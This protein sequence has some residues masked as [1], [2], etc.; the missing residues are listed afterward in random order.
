MKKEQRAVPKKNESS[1][2]RRLSLALFYASFTC[3]VLV[4]SMGFALLA[5]KLFIHYDVLMHIPP[6]LIPDVN[7]AILFT[8]LVSLTVG[9]LLSLP[10]VQVQISPLNRVITAMNRLASGDYRERLRFRRPTSLMPSYKEMEISFN[11][12]AEE[13]ENTEL[14]RS[15]FINNFSH[16]FKTP[17][18]SIAGFARLLQRGELTEEQR[19]EYL[20]AIY[21]ESLR[22]SNMATNVL[23]LSHL[24]KQTILSH[25]SRYNVSEQIRSC[26]L[27]LEHAWS[28][29]NIDWEIEMEEYEIEGDEELIKQVWINILSNA[30]KFSPADSC[31]IL[32][33]S[34]TEGMLQVSVSN[35]GTI[36]SPEQPKIWH[37]F[38]QGDKSHSGTGHGIGLAIVKRIAELHGGS[39][40]AES[41]DGNVVIS[42]TFPQKRQGSFVS[43]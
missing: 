16:E 7:E 35:P 32:R 1:F 30:V 3:L 39:V 14:L 13:L 27:L 15:D 29:K 34:L 23:N 17:I 26:V 24:E 12:L 25:V 10:V 22:L 6:E 28:V 31:I 19:R 8:L 5:I 20:E 2:R 11:K 38:Y 42:V 40:G 33:A 37:K 41:E 18:V 21:E 4:L 43:V 9:A 36:L